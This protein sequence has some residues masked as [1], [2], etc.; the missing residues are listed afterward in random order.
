MSGDGGFVMNCQE[1]ETAVRCGTPFVN[2]VW[3]N[4]QFGS[5]AWKQ[6]R[7]FDRHFGTDFGNPDFVELGGR[8]ACRRGGSSRPTSSGPGSRHAHPRRS[9]R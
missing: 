9:R 7:R 4:H 1:L 8:S 6:Q 5:I 3:E 2:L